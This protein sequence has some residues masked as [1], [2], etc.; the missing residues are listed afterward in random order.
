MDGLIRMLAEREE[1]KAK[2]HCCM[3]TAYLCYENH[4]LNTQPT[5][6]VVVFIFVSR[7]SSKIL[8]W[9]NSYGE[10]RVHI[11]YDHILHN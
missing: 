5:R 10:H 7:A 4:N 1:G 2:L 11:G 6:L 3:P 9:C 8:A